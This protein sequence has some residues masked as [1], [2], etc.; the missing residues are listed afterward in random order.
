MLSQASPDK[1]ETYASYQSIDSGSATSL[2]QPHP[3]KRAEKVTIQ[4]P[5][6]NFSTVDHPPNFDT[7]A[8]LG[9]GSVT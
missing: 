9:Y 1:N 8:A 5:E 7:L 6:Q 4:V 2:I 3:L